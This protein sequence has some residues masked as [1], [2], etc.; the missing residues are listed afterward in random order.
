LRNTLLWLKITRMENAQIII[1]GAGA[2]GLMAGI[3]AGRSNPNRRIV[4]LDGAPK[5]GRKILIAGG[6]RCNVTHHE[7]TEQAYAGASRNAIK[8]VLRQFNVDQTI[9]FF[10][11]LGVKLKQEETGKLFP[12]T[13]KASTVL[14]A[15]MQEVGLYATLLTNHRV[16]TITSNG[17]R[18]IV[19]GNFGQMSAQK[20]IL[21]TG[22]KSIPKTGSDGR[23][24][25]IAQELGHSL[26][27]RIFPALVPLTVPRKHWIRDLKGITVPTTLELWTSTGKRLESF[28]NSMLCT[29]FGLS[30]PGVLDMSRYYLE[31][32]GH[33]SKVQ[34]TLNWVPDWESEQFAGM[35]KNE[36]KQS[37]Q[38][39]LRNKMPDRLA[40]TLLEQS[41]GDLLEAHGV[42]Q[43]ANQLSKAE[44][45]KVVE[46]VTRFPVPVAG[47][48]GFDFAEVTAG[49]VP[50]NELHLNTLLSRIC[51]NLYFCGEIL[52]VDGRIGGFNFQWAWAS[53]YLAGRAV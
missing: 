40:R 29:H 30:G 9:D 44:R 2:A 52:D 14:E 19:S 7:V 41:L 15:L 27:P 48:R 17:D 50:L 18:F 22:G 25:E 39:I 34:L 53:G 20:V 16:E 8:K 24:Y 33:D 4:L 36:R 11:R 1:V 32:L 13:D 42:Q 45:K 46:T 35:L 31:A 21:A 23:G 43:P 3:W 26:T 28:T 38:Q 12:T 5:I 49:G 47:N 37:V 10:K 6:G 51:P